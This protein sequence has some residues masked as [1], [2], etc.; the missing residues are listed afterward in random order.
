MLSS[1]YAMSAIKSALALSTWAAVHSLLATS[2]VKRRARARLGARR[3][4]AMY[5]LGYNLFAGLSLAVLVRYQWTLPDR[6]LYTVRGPLRAVMLGGQALSLLA[7]VAGALRVGAGMF[8]GF[9]QLGEY[10]RGRPISPG[11]VSQHP[12]PQRGK[13]RPNWGG[14][15]KLSR[16]PLNYFI[17]TI[18]W[19]SP[20]M[21]VKWAAVGVVT[22][23][24]MV[25]GSVHEGRLLREAYGDRYL[26]YR[27]EVP[28]FLL[29]VGRWLGR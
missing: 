23:V 15:Y 25:L 10:L 16:H 24:Y 17:L 29:P 22:A 12:P 21:T 26:R 4:D 7:V 13:D 19:F 20:V 14:P 3:S 28:H 1:V 11:P 27:E 8:P 5:R 18:Y 9:T 6:R 2:R